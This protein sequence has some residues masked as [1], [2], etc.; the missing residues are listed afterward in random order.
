MTNNTQMTIHPNLQSFVKPADHAKYS[1]SSADRWW[2]GCEYSVKA[3]EDIPNESNKYAEEGTT[4]HAVCEAYYREQM[5][6]LSFPLDLQLDM[7][8]Y[9][10]KGAEMMDAA[11]EFFD[12]CTYWMNTDKVGKVLWYGQERGIPVFPEFGCYGTGDFII[13]GENA[14]VV[15]DF[16]YG[17]RPVS[18]S[19][20][21]LKVYAAGIARHI[22]K[23]KADYG[24]FAV[25]HQP[26]VEPAVKEI[27]YPITEL[28]QSLGSIQASIKKSERNDNEPQE[29][30]H[31]FW[32]PARK[33]KDE[34]KR[35]KLIVNKPLQLVQENFA[36]FMADS[37]LVPD[38]VVSKVKR[39]EAIVKLMTLLPIIQ[40]VVEQSKEDFLNR[41]AAGEHIPGVTIANRYGNREFNSVDDADSAAMIIDL[42]PDIN[43]YRVVSAT[44]LKTLGQLEK[45]VGKGNLDPILKKKITKEVKILDETEKKIINSM[46]DF[47]KSISMS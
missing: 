3:S 18:A 11:A 4:A 45:E 6:G 28:Y 46:S 7:A 39:D 35:C 20:K 1:P 30:S 34:S 19:S 10:D 15:I 43:P 36:K 25:V 42:F 8:K 12:V 23:V 29:G 32:C 14:S 40:S 16:K 17:R 33:A 44:K 37:N 2:G 31:C 47:A 38:T 22:D 9:P 41:M 13:I 26:R 24:I 5:I 27:Y 21:Q